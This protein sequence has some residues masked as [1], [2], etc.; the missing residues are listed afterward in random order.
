MT[1]ELSCKG[2]TSNNDISSENLGVVIAHSIMNTDYFISYKIQGSGS[3][4]IQTE[5]LH[6]ILL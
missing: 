4:P 1:L 2:H 3:L 5:N 6:V